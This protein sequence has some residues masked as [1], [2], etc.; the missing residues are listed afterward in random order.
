MFLAGS[1]YVSVWLQ[2]SGP[3][4][5]VDAYTE[6]N[7]VDRAV[8]SF[9]IAAGVFVLWRRNIDWGQ[10][11]S[12]NK[13]V[14][15][16]FMYCGVSILWSDY[17]F[18]SL[19]R[20]VKELGN[21]VMILVILTEE[22]PYEAVG[23]LLR[24]LA[25]LWLPLSV[26]LIRFYPELGRAYHANGVPMY[27]GVGYQK[28]DLGLICLISG[29]YFF[30]NFL[31][32]R[33]EGLERRGSSTLV[34]ILLVAMVA[35]LLRMAHSA[36]A[37]GCFL[38]AAGMLFISGRGFILRKPDRI[39]GLLM[40]LSVS[41][42]I[43]DEALSLREAAI[44]ALGRDS[45]LTAR[46]G[47]WEELKRMTT[48][49]IVGAGF[50]SFWA[51]DRLRIL[52]EKFGGLINQ[53]HNGYLEQ[54]L[55]LGYVGLVFIGV[56]LLSGV[57]KV[58]THLKVDYPAAILRLCFI[59]VALLYNYTEASFYGLNDMWLLTLLGVIEISV[60]ERSPRKLCSP[61]STLTQGS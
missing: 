23:T 24:R 19:K 46:V 48:N 42:I 9:L 2:L 12:R 41:F 15:L 14:W 56:V 22:H 28:N 20:F 40:L 3:L 30:W 47:I 55:N 21:L 8:F 37:I 43:L 50:M 49:P 26:L 34:D 51:G 6:G 4:S 5:T 44:G 29:I 54:Y 38:V 27:T 35:W 59:T 57:M 45:T 10:V 60:Q 36:T 17:S 31:F 1:R 7:P 58:R 18:I 39:I 53:A 61:P 33:K 11:L 52:C 32:N 25:F 13:W 16:Y